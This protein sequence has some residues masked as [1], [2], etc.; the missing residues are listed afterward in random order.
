[1]WECQLAIRSNGEETTRH[2]EMKSKDGKKDER[3]FLGR[4]IIS[5]WRDSISKLQ[6]EVSNLSPEPRKTIAC[7]GRRQLCC[8]TKGQSSSRPDP[9]RI[10]HFRLRALSTPGKCRQSWWAHKFIFLRVQ[11]DS[12]KSPAPINYALHRIDPD[13]LW[14]PICNFFKER[15]KKLT[16]KMAN[17]NKG[18]VANEASAQTG[19]IQKDD[20]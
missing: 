2:A 5:N 17:R 6:L 19:L 13:F 14:N 9:F 15:S 16:T 11:C 4:K 1:M 7:A 18:Q 10:K 3:F 20:N 12:K 8:G